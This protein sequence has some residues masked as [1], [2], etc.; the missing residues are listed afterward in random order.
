MQVVIDGMLGMGD[1]IYQFPI[2]KAIA[3]AN[4]DVLLK[5]PWPQIYESIPN[6]GFAPLET[7]LRTQK[8][9]LELMKMRAD[10]SFSQIKPGYKP[11]HLSYV[12]FQKVG[13]P[14]WQGLM[15]SA[16]LGPAFKYFLK[17]REPAKERKPYVVIRPA[18]IR[19][20]WRAMSRNPSPVYIQFAIDYI[21]K[22]RKD[23]AVIVVADVDPP[24]EIYDGPRPVGATTY[25]EN[26][27]LSFLELLDLVHGAT[28]VIGG[29]GFIAPMCQALGT[30]CVII[31]GGAGARNKPQMIDCPAEGKLVHVVPNNYCLCHSQIHDCNKTIEINR[32]KRAIDVKILC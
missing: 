8:K 1:N 12:N 17:L 25:Y 9:N 13:I 14:L 31:H 26:G 27:E 4:R 5:T 10:F 30:P 28:G 16:K 11:V 2:V 3:A 19:Q 32:L 18:T 22:S 20:E 29:V 24:R 6:L 21:R 7:S 15:R 23:L